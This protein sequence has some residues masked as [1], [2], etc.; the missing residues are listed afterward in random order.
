MCLYVLCYIRLLFAA[1]SIV[2]V[3]WANHDFATR[4]ACK[5]RYT[6][7]TMLLKQH[8]AGTQEKSWERRCRGGRRQNPRSTRN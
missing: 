4:F 8:G 2:I 6:P 7:L 3:L 5:S 1:K